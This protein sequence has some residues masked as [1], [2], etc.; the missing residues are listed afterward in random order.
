MRLRFAALLLLFAGCSPH[1]DLPFLG[2]VPAFAMISQDGKAFNSES[3]AGHVWIADFIF[4]HCEGACLRMSS[5][6]HKVQTATASDPQIRLLSFTVDPARDSP[7]VMAAFASRYQANPA[8]WSF[9]TGEPK[10]LQILSRDTFKLSD[11][12]GSLNHSTRFVLVDKRGRVRGIYGTQDDD[13]VGKVVADA[14]Q[15]QKE[16][17]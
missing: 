1:R 16:N 8:R 3:L 10:T 7:A 17:S 6:M 11:V 14:R 5:Q 9:L 2:Q 4:T 15:L 12:D 13:P